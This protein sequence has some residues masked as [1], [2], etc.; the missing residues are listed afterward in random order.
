MS[1]PSSGHENTMSYLHF[2]H[3]YVVFSTRRKPTPNHREM[4]PRAEQVSKRQELGK[5]MILKLKRDRTSGFT[6]RRL[7]TYGRRQGWMDRL[8]AD[9]CP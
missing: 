1:R 2:Q 4:G 9:A 7:F 3:V 8:K 5:P 6:L